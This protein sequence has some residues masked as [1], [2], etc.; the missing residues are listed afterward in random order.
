M[1]VFNEIIFV[2]ASWCTWS[3]P[4]PQ[5]F[6]KYSNRTVNYTNRTIT[7]TWVTAC[8]YEHIY[9]NSCTHKHSTHADLKNTQR[10]NRDAC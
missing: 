1:T 3:C 9:T 2:S 7:S 10:T 5:G 4:T 6:L 8:K